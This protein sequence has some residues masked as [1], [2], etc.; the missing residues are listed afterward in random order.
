MF[1]MFFLFLGLVVQREGKAPPRS[2][3][4]GESELITK[5][6]LVFMRKRLDTLFAERNTSTFSS[7]C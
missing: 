2:D 6:A 1:M 5:E 3:L 4:I 7:Q